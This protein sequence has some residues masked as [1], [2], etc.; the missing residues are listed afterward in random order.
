MKKSHLWTGAGMVAA[1]I[2]FLLAALLLDTPLGS[3]FAGFSGA[4]TAPGVVQICKYIKWTRPENAALYQERL[5][6]E[7]IELRDERKALLREKAGRLA[8]I[9]GLLV[10]AVSITVFSFLG[11]LGIV[12]QAAS[13]LVILFLGGYLLVQLLAAEAVYR[14]LSRKY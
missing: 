1:G 11:K 5:E 14:V 4:F 10:C 9:F 2:L 8:Y 3:L 13:R 7:Q 6:A 12:D